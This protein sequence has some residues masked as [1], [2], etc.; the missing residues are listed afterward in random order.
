[1]KFQK[2]SGYPYQSRQQQPAVINSPQW[3]VY[4]YS[5][6]VPCKQRI[7]IL[8]CVFRQSLICK[9]IVIDKNVKYIMNT[10]NIYRGIERTF[11]QTGGFPVSCIAHLSI[12]CYWYY[13]LDHQLLPINWVEYITVTPENFTS[14][15]IWNSDG[16]HCRDLVE[17]PLYFEFCPLRRFNIS[18]ISSDIILLLF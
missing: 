2:S 13:K 12:S 14:F 15:K 16:Y 9:W 7:K 5:S 11:Q 10:I 6:W 17:E 8:L 3:N 1:M 18:R 4:F